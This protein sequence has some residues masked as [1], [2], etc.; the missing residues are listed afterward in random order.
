LSLMYDASFICVQTCHL[1][2]MPL[3]YVYRLVTYVWC[4][5]RMRKDVS[6]M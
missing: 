6:L 2:M 3:S 1:C 5:F 4:L